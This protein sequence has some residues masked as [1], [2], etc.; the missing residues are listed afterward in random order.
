MAAGIEPAATP[1][2]IKVIGS[3]AREGSSAIL[4]DNIPPIKTM[5]GEADI[6]SGCEINNN[7]IFLGRV[8]I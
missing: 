2:I 6:T 3:V 7:Q 8:N 4:L 5:I 1:R